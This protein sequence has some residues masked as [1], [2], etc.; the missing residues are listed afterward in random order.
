MA[1][2]VTSRRGFLRGLGAALCAPAVVRAGILMPIKAPVQRL[3]VLFYSLQIAPEW[4]VTL[5][6]DTATILRPMANALAD[7]VAAQVLEQ[8]D[9]L[10]P[11]GLA[12]FAE[13][14]LQVVLPEQRGKY[15][16]LGR[17]L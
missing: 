7:R 1:L 4:S 11:I 17:L 15:L 6:D 13:K 12:T 3:D 8:R 10:F 5:N 14:P 16:P 2:S 9:E